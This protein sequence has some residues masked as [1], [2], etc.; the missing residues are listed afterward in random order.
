M[1]SRSSVCDRV[2]LIGEAVRSQLRGRVRIGHFGGLGKLSYA[3]AEAWMRSHR[4]KFGLTEG[5]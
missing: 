2:D 4:V 1:R 5:F 3:I